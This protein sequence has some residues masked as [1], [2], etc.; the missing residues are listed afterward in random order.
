M[1]LG[2]AQKQDFTI[3]RNTPDRL[4]TPLEVPVSSV[5]DCCFELPVL[6]KSGGDNF[7]NDQS[8]VIFFY[9]GAFITAS[10]T[11]Q[12]YENGAFVD[13]VSLN[14]NTYG[15]FFAFG[16]EVNDLGENLMGYLIDW[17]SVL[18]DPTLGQGT[19]RVKTLETTVFGAPQLEQFSI[20]FC[21]K[22][23]TIYQANL[24]V[25]FDWYNTGVIGDPDNDERIRDYGTLSY[26]NQMRLPESIFGNDTDETE[27]SSVRY[28]NGQEVWL[29]DNTVEVYTFKSGRYPDYIHKIL[30]YDMMKADIIKVSNYDNDAHNLHNDHK[31]VPRS[32]YEPNYIRGT[33]LS[34]V[35]L[36]FEQEFRNNRHKRC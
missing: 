17:E 21:L 26:L 3:I 15:T 33:K 16:F 31:I 9:D 20:A 28:Q 29:Q 18:L 13:K 6:A 10:M 36:T 25:R 34:S 27:R 1:A 11:L 2:E 24:T 23:Y 22:T 35:E 19:Y 14:N 5:D 8:S 30:R 4:I 32:N 12:K 7:T